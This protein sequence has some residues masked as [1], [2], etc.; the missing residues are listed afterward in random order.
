MLDVIYCPA[1][2][3]GIQVKGL[4][5][6]GRGNTYGNCPGCGRK[7]TLGLR[8]SSG[9]KLEIGCYHRGVKDV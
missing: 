5:L 6:D 8:R 3:K 9:K 4:S 7:L 2:G 1:C